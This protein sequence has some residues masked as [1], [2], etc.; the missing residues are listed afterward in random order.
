MQLH[1]YRMFSLTSK[2]WYFLVHKERYAWRQ[3]DKLIWHF[4]HTLLHDSRVYFSLLIKSDLDIKGRINP[5]GRGCRKAIIFA[6]PQKGFSV[7]AKINPRVHRFYWTFAKI[8][9]REY[10][11]GHCSRKFVH[12][13]IN[14]R[15][16]V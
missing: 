1:S 15:K 8:N 6:R 12:T 7:L 10:F 9:P 2:I 11:W 13:K 5:W 3:Q 16:V 14:P 4:S